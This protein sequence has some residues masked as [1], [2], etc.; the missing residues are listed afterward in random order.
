MVTVDKKPLQVSSHASYADDLNKQVEFTY[1]SFDNNGVKYDLEYNG[2]A[3]GDDSADVATIGSLKAGSLSKTADAG[4]PE[5]PIIKQG[6]TTTVDGNSVT[7][8]FF[9]RNYAIT[10]IPGTVKVSKAPLTI[11]ADD[12][13]GTYGLA[14]PAYGAPSHV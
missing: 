13:M 1:G 6:E 5:I 7:L 3:N 14:T 8:P 2:L 12:A 10:L 9:S 4:T 11:A